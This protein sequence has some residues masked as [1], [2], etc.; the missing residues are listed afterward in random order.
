M[1]YGELQKINVELV[2]RGSM[3][4]K[5]APRPPTHGVDVQ[6]F[7]LQVLHAL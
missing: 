2:C 1:T 5:G 4:A 3:L 6:S 7:S